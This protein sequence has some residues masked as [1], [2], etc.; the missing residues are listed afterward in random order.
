MSKQFHAKNFWYAPKNPGTLAISALSTEFGPFAR[1]CAMMAHENE[2]IARENE[3]NEGDFPV[4]T[5]Q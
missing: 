5:R 4:K 1:L 3:T 2:H